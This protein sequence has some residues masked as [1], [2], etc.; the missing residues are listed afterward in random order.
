MSTLLAYGI[1]GALVAGVG[2]GELSGPSGATV[3]IAVAVAALVVAGALHRRALVAVVALALASGAAGTALM[4]RALD[5][6]VHWPLAAAV[7]R[8]ADAV[9]DLTLVDDP[10]GSR[11]STRVLA[12][13]TR[14][15][16]DGR[17]VD[18]GARTLLVVASDDAGPRVGLLAAGDEVRLRGWLRPLD[19]FDERLRWRHAVARFDASDVLAFRGPDDLLSRSAGAIRDTVLRGTTP[20]PPTQRALVAGFLLGDTRGL[21]DDVLEGFRAAGLSHL[22]AVSGAN[23][24]FVLALAGPLLARLPRRG[25]L[26]AVLAVLVVFGAMTRWEP[27][28]MRA[29]AMA[30]CTVVALHTGRPLRATRALA[31]AVAV[32]VAVDPFLV[33]SVG[34]LLSCGACLGIAVLAPPI[35]GWL[36]GPAWL[37]EGLATT[38]AAQLG[39]APVL[40]P[41]FGS[42]PLISLAANL[43]AMPLAAPLTTWG[44]TS[45]ALG[46]VVGRAAPGVATVAQVPTRML[47][48]AMLGVADAAARVPLAIDVRGAV[49][50]ALIAAPVVVAGRARMLRRHA[51]VVPPR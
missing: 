13:V 7:E 32:L 48:D 3:A 44:L 51:L 25:R 30:A 14:A 10:D 36:R 9:L 20:L 6:R 4:Q 46:G 22:L 8:R 21:P 43:V 40:L 27:S 15:V 34:F 33:H 37:R 17:A 24:A 26:L 41:V 5:G 12:R 28:V 45:G 38:A 39:V 31:I 1:L 35:A 23:V 2:V 11:F 47:A 50:L 42:V 19:G 18:A 29:C 49:V 16:V